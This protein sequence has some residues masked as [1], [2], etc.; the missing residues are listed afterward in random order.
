MPTTDKHNQIEMIEE[1]VQ[2]QSSPEGRIEAP[3]YRFKELNE[4]IA[5]LKETL[6]RESH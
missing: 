6:S 2:D 4:H 5:Y 3:A 1:F